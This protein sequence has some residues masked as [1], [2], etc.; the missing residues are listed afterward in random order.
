M[1]VGSPIRAEAVY[2]EVLAAAGDEALVHAPE[3]GVDVV[4]SL[5]AALELAQQALVLQ[6]PQ[7]HALRLAIQ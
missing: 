3:A 1:S 4:R 5:R 6:V 2:L 7:V